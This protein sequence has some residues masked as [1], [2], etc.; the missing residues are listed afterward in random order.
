MA[1]MTKITQSG[2]HPHKVKL[3]YFVPGRTDKRRYIFKK[4]TSGE[5]S[6][7]LLALRKHYFENVNII[8]E[9]TLYH[10]VVKC[11]YSFKLSLHVPVLM[12]T[13]VNVKL[14]KNMPCFTH[15]TLNVCPQ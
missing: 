7:I 1:Q 13:T 14:L 6:C 11:N 15:A 4:K 8:R 5:T 3:P 12:Q 9:L 10:K 2:S